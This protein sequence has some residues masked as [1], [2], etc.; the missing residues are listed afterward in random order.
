MADYYNTLYRLW[1]VMALGAGTPLLID[2]SEHYSDA[3]NM[4]L[5]LKNGEGPAAAIKAAK[6]ITL[7]SAERMYELC[8]SKGISMTVPEDD[9]FPKR[10]KNIRH[11]P[12]ML[13]YK[14]DISGIDDRLSI[15]VV[16]TRKPDD[17]SRKVT[18]A[19]V[20]TL[21]PHEFDIVSGFAEGIDICAHISA[22]KNGLKTYA[23]LGCGVDAVYPRAN[24]KY[25]PFIIENGAVISEHLPGTEPNHVHFRP[26]NRIISGLSMGT[27]V[28]QAGPTSGSL[29]TASHAADQGKPVFAVPP[30]DIFDDSYQGNKELLRQ[31]A[32]VLMGARDIY[33]EYCLNL[34]HTIVVADAVREKLDRLSSA[35]DLAAEREKADRPKKTRRIRKDSDNAVKKA[36]EEETSAEEIQAE[37]IPAA[38]LPE[39]ASDEERAVL[40]ALMESC[41]PMS[42]DEIAESCS[43]DIVTVLSALTEMEIEG[44]VTAAAG[45]FKIT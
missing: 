35:M 15:A 16:G 42:A 38:A 5:A 12:V 23:V 31:G 1:S 9:D 44:A 22:I 43:L 45:K 17:Y 36:A 18:S 39:D 33:S 30:Y 2:T 28:I 6:D 14:G 10:L 24:E 3:E 26:R 13:F 25:K 11:C 27:A 29:N 32:V 37:E 20:N 34:P 7:D 21:A 8:Q 4:Y 41:E 19:I 40:A